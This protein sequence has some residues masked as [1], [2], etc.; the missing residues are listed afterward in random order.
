MKI[1]YVISCGHGLLLACGLFLCRADTARAQINVTNYGALGDL[2][3]LGSV[4]AVSNSTALTCPGANFSGSDTNKLIEVFGAGTYEGQSNMDLFAQIVMVTSP[5][6][7]TIST[8]AGATMTNLTGL[9]GTDD[10]PPFTNAIANCPVPTGVINIPAG[11]YFLLPPVAFSTNG[12]NNSLNYTL[13]LRRGGITFAGQGT[14]VLTGMGGWVN[15]LNQANRSALVALTEPMTNNYPLVF[16]NLIL[17]GGTA[18]GNVLNLSY[19]PSGSTGVGWDG[20]HHWM[21]TVGGTGG[22]IDSLVMLNCIVRHWRGEMM[23]ETSGAPNFFLTASNCLF[24]DGDG[25]CINN[26]AH[27]CAACTF[28][29]ANQAEEFYR[30]YTTNASTMTNCFFTDLANGIALNGGYYGDPFYTI[31]DCVFTNFYGGGYD[32]LTSPAC[33]AAF[34]NNHVYTPQGIA[35]GVAGYQGDTVNSNIIAAYNIFNGAQYPLQVFGNGADLSEQVYFFSNQVNNAWGIGSGYGWSTNVYVFNNTSSNC[36]WFYEVNFS[37][38][39]FIDQSNQYSP[40]RLGDSIAQTN[41]FSYDDGRLGDILPCNPG[42]IFALD[43][44]ET[45]QIPINALM[46]IS[47]TASQTFPL[48]LSVSMTG[49]LVMLNAGQSDTFYWNGLAWTNVPV[50]IQSGTLLVQ[51]GSLSYGTILSGTSVTN[52]FTVQNTGTG[53]LNGTASVTAPFSIVAGGTYNLEASQS[54]TVSVAFSPTA[55][56]SYNQTMTFTGGGGTNVTLSGSA[57]NALPAIPVISL[58]PAISGSARI[59]N[60][61]FPTQTN[62][63]YQLECKTNLTDAIWFPS[64]SY[65]GS[66]G[67]ITFRVTNNVSL[68]FYRL[69]VQ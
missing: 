61:S 34:L 41:V 55:A 37:G 2:L 36:N 9:Y 47:N 10:Y 50:V 31:I 57:T 29:N 65:P 67:V 7:I 28:S 63:T 66:G 6:N 40:Y 5:S 14:A 22:M 17:D 3:T 16:T 27:Y 11:N 56:G 20:T 58:I 32:L 8:P 49:S 21:V 15:Y 64:E 59:L 23:E 52:N 44:T 68:Q 12:Y 39:Y 54:Q 51:P 19:P 30:S 69:T 1:R 53:T 45:A 13:V 4:S 38:Q 42:S 46:V 25:S 33:D 18:I 48:Y 26:F 24:C 35:L 62:F 60:I 43:D